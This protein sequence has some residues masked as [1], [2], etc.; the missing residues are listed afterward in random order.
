[1]KTEGR[2]GRTKVFPQRIGGG[3]ALLSNTDGLLAGIVPLWIRPALAAPTTG[4]EPGET[5]YG[6]DVVMRAVPAPKTDDGRP[7]GTPGH[8][9]ILVPRRGASPPGNSQMYRGGGDIRGCSSPP[10][11]L[12]Q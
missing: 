3:L 10:F 5:V 1:M 6:S 9:G 7:K 11:V 4:G 8:G 2:D 12:S